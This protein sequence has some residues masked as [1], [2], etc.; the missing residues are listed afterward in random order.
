MCVCV[1]GGRVLSNISN[2]WWK[3]SQRNIHF[4]LLFSVSYLSRSRAAGYAP[5]FPSRYM[6]DN[7]QL[8]F[9]DHC[10]FSRAVIIRCHHFRK[11]SLFLSQVTIP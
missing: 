3:T 4:C 7:P 5:S 10:L 2:Y 9:V 6:I 11:V 1:S 8:L